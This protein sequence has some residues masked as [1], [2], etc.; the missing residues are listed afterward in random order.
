MRWSYLW[1]TSPWLYL[2]GHFVS[3]CVPETLK[4]LTGSVKSSQSKKSFVALLTVSAKIPQVLKIR[5]EHRTNNSEN[6]S[7]T[8]IRGTCFAAGKFSKEFY[9][10][11]VKIVSFYFFQLK[12][13]LGT[14]AVRI[15]KLDNRIFTLHLH[16]APKQTHCRE[17]W[18][19]SNESIGTENNQD[20]SINPQW[21]NI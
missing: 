2:L 18:L 14:V 21:P 6:P 15:Q 9:V 8:P 4:N 5:I 13:F 3:D 11:I 10:H 19:Y 20:V 7:S 1:L 16:F 17:V 12:A